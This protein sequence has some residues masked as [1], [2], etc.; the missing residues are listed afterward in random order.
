MKNRGVIGLEYIRVYTSMN[1][2]LQFPGRSAISVTKLL[3]FLRSVSIQMINDG[4]RFFMIF[5]CCAQKRPIRNKE[6]G[7]IFVLNY[8]KNA[9]G[10]PAP[11]PICLW[12]RFV[13][14]SCFV[15]VWSGSSRLIAPQHGHRP[16]SVSL[17]HQYSP[18]HQ[19]FD[20]RLP[21]PNRLMMTFVGA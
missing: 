12:T 5:F 16:A 11:P 15:S 13:W 2:L 9:N 10:S 21:T 4:K 8:P 18:S 17:S 6:E 7:V 14:Q 3:Y 1:N 20:S 19:A